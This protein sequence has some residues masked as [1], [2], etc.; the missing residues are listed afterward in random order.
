MATVYT[1]SVE[2]VEVAPRDGLQNEKVE[3][4]TAHKLALIERAIDAGARRI[5]VT[6]FVNPKA[7]PQMADA[8]AVCSGL[9]Q[10]DDV[11][12]IGLVMNQRGADRA[13]ATGRIDQLGAVC[14]AT[15]TFAM[16]NQGQTSDGSV[17]AASAIIASAK[18][19]GKTAQA[20]IAASFGCPFEGE[21]EEARVIAMAKAIAQVSPVEIAL[22]DTIGVGNP[23]HVTR[24]IAGV[25]EAVGDIPIR[26][27][28]HNTRGTGLANVWA[29]VEAGASTIDASIGGLGGCPFAPGAAGNVATEDVQYMLE[30]AGI[31]T[32]L[33]LAKLIETNAWLAPIMGKDLPAM[34]AKSGGFP[35][36]QS[37][38][39]PEEKEVA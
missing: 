32:G 16:R 24:L 7:V 10:R 34:V 15:D 36:P 18:A 13:L 27:H 26:M 4:S 11:T 2:I 22:A 6:S 25:K 35:A 30:R 19:A 39:K 31:S 5:E 21:V 33:D 20:T 1:K 8:D 29:A 28:F 3:V 23:A 9:P 14:V 38:E 37:E 12:Y 17:E